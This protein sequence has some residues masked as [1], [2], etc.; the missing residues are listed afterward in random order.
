MFRRTTFARCFLCVYVVLLLIPTGLVANADDT[1][2]P[3]NTVVEVPNG[4]T[5]PAPQP[6][7]SSI[8]TGTRAGHILDAFNAQEQTILFERIPFT[9]DEEKA[10]FEKDKKMFSLQQ[11]LAHIEATKKDLQSQS[12]GL[13]KRQLNLQDY[14][15][16][17]DAGIAA[18]QKDIDAVKDKITSTNVNIGNY[19]RD[20]QST[21]TRIDANKHAILEYLTY[22]YS[23]GDL[24]YSSDQNDIDIMKTIIMNDGNISDIFN[25]IHYKSILELAG[26]N[27]IEQYR[28]LVDEY[29]DSKQSLR[30]EKINLLRLKAQLLKNQSDLAAQVR[31]K[32]KILDLTKGKEDLFDAYITEKRQAEN[33]VQDRMTNLSDGYEQTYQEIGDKFHCSNVASAMTNTLVHDDSGSTSTGLVVIPNAHKNIASKIS[34]SS[35]GSTASGSTATRSDSSGSTVIAPD[36]TAPDGPDTVN[37]DIFTDSGLTNCQRVQAY[38]LAEKQ[39]HDYESAHS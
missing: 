16:D 14:I 13:L 1:N 28:K 21:Q 33:S 35:S 5:T 19:L 39:L 30:D 38:Y 31:I 20:I 18:N 8:P 4:D 25:D 12:L 6:T 11:M 37:T 36:S 22:I 3:D 27:F 24:V 23:R 32:Q 26:Q 9:S 34:L 17:L 15:S 2:T 29:Y 10:L 7:N